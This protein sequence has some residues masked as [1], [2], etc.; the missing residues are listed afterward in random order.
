MPPSLHPHLR[1]LAAAADNDFYTCPDDVIEEPPLDFHDAG[2]RAAK[3]TRVE[4]IA[5]QYLR[6]RPPVILTASLRGPFDNGWKNPWAKSKKEK[7][8]ALGRI[9]KGKAARPDDARPKRRGSRTQSTA[10]SVAPSIAS[11]ETSRA[12][13]DMN[14]SA[15]EHDTSL[16]DVQVPPSTAPL[17]GGDSACPTA[18]PFSADTGPRIHRQS[19][20]TNPFWLRRPDS[21]RVDMRRAA[22]EHPDTSPT[23]SRSR[24]HDSQTESVAELQVSLPKG[25][26]QLQRQSPRV[27]SPHHGRSSASASM[28]ISSPA[29]DSH[30]PSSA[31]Q[32]QAQSAT[33]PH[34][35]HPGQRSQRTI[36]IVTSSM[37]SQSRVSR[38][39]IQRSAE[40]LVN[41]MSASQ[42]SGLKALQETLTPTQRDDAA[43]PVPRPRT[44]QKTGKAG[45]AGGKPPKPRPRAVNFDSSPEKGSPTTEQGH[46]ASTLGGFTDAAE[47]TEAS[48]ASPEPVE[49]AT[50]VSENGEVDK[51]GAS[52]ESEWSTQAAMVR[53]QLEFQQSTFPALSPATLAAESQTPLITPRAMTGVSNAATT[54]LRALNVPR[55]EALP[56]G[57]V[58]RGPP[59]STQDLF[60][61]ASP[62]SFST[63]KKKT[64][65]ALKPSE[66]T[67][68]GSVKGERIP[69]KDKKTMSSFWSFVTDKASQGSPGCL[70]ER[71]RCSVREIEAPHV[72]R[73]T[74]LDDFGRHF[75]GAF[76]RGIDDG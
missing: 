73:D 6:G 34:S 74:S 72:N 1:H 26:V 45:D 60:G 75:T 12:T 55:D 20:S 69:L 33:P 36:P 53:A 32:H 35:T 14:L 7:Q 56:N 50:D 28:D 70:G 52:R 24:H 58:S 17:P 44:C 10:R 63:A 3:R 23:R 29:R 19:P 66:A 15:R 46:E 38:D 43:S 62:F 71:S 57:G 13:R 48:I 41:A 30:V 22:N 11:P 67:P 4:A 5:A 16:H 31:M 59:I 25:P 47:S 27:L 64:E 68:S 8:R 54:P 2:L 18:E 49:D 61:A 51:S 65:E 39:D 37:G 9:G 76:L 40:R 21:A 42:L